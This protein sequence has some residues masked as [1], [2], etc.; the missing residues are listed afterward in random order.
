MSAL[1]ELGRKRLTVVGNSYG[2]AK[3]IHERAV[4]LLDRETGKPA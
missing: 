4:A 2:D 1:G 3:A